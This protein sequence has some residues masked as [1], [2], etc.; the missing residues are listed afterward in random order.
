MSQLRK[1]KV[2]GVIRKVK[3]KKRMMLEEEKTEILKRKRERKG[4]NMRKAWDKTK[5]DRESKEINKEKNLN[6][7]E[8]L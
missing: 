5:H 3:K 7:Y 6:I 2:F 8:G 1:I 4:D